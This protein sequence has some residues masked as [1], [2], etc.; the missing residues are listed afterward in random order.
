MNYIT[1][2][3]KE[4]TLLIYYVQTQTVQLLKKMM[5]RKIFVWIKTCFILVIM[6]EIQNFDKKVICKMKDEFKGEIISEF[7]GLKSKMY[8][9]IAVDGGEIKKAKRVNKNLW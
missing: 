5:V 3:L 9:L 2:T 6:H 8:F 1:N 4:N 7:A